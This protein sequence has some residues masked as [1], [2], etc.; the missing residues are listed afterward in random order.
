MPGPLAGRRIWF[1]GIGGAGL[2]GYALLANAWGAEVAGWD[3]VDT[4]Y[5][6]NVRAAGI[7]VT[8]GPE[9][10][11][12]PAGWDAVVSSAF[13][14]RVAGASRAAFLAELV[15]LQRAI[16]VAGAHGKTTTAAMVAFVLD[17]LG[18]DPSF[19]IGGDVPQLGGNA[20]AGTGWLVVEGDE[21]DRTIA[22]LRP[23][24][25]VVTNLDLDHH[26]E[27]ASRAEVEQLFDEWLEHVPVVVRG[28]TVPSVGIALAVPGEHNR[29]NAAAAVAAVA[30]AG[31][32]PTAAERAIAEFRG[33]GRRLELRG[34]NGVKVYDDYAH[35]PAKVAAAIAAARELGAR[36]LVVFQPHLFSRTRHLA[37]ELAVALSAADVVAVT[38]VYPAREEPI[39]GVTGRLVVEAL[40]EVRPGMPV[41][42]TPALED[43]ARFVSGRARE[44]DVVLT[45]G[46][47]DVDRVAPLIVEALA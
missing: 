47:G 3:K 4:P 28:D 42:W 2:S 43:G 5:L 14:G 6:D 20:R 30:A 25:A 10:V 16:V 12:A 21:S 35:N 22:S 1:V 7:G 41:A 39:E 19:L 29:R 17:R 13:A 32:S 24:I 38:D 9:P 18:L 37:R 34:A 46:A 11:A 15:S 31:V 44:G 45:V 36:V 27:F 26:T 23:E 8:I 40:T 33:V